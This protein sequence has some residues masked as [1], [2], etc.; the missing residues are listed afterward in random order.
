MAT[1]LA[2]GVHF[3]TSTWSDTD[4]TR[5]CVGVGTVCTCHTAVADSVTE[6]V[7]NLFPNSEFTAFLGGVREGA[8]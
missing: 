8:L 2:E 5:S 7:L 1:F 4:W 6:D 3:R